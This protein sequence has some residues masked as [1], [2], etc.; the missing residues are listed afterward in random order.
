M[1]KKLNKI[2]LL[3]L[4]ALLATIGFVMTSCKED[5]TVS[6]S[7][8]EL[9]SFGPS[10]IQ[11]G[12]NIS[13]IGKNLDKVLSITF[14]GDSLTQSS[15]LKQ[16]PELIQA[17]VP[18]KA[19]R[20]T[21]ALRTLKGT[22]VSKTILDFLVPVTIGTFTSPVRPGNNITINGQ[23]VNYIKQVVFAKDLIVKD[24]FFVSRSVNHIVVKVPQ[25]AQT[26]TLNFVTGGTDPLTFTSATDLVVIL[27]AFTGY[28][29]NPVN[30]GDNLTITGT[31]LDLTQ[32]IY[33]N[34]VSAVVQTFV[35]KTATQI[36]VKVP[37]GS[38]KGRVTLV[39][40]SGVKVV[41]G[42]K[43][44]VT[45][46]LPAPAPLPYAFFMNGL[47]NGWG[48]WGWGGARNFKSTDFTRGDND[49]SIKVNCDASWG[50]VQFGGGSVATSTYTKV[51]FS[52]Y[53]GTGS[54]GKQ[55]QVMANWGT[56]TT[57]TLV[58]GVW[59]DYE[60]TMPALGNPGTITAL[61]FQEKGF[62][63]FYYLD[64]VGLR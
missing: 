19:E 29:P 34:G 53:G 35:S 3:P 51:V 20:G 26:G 16:T 54:S 61:I 47:Q 60:I 1:M 44:G 14:K 45:G 64:F 25:A 57:I 30:P 18:Q 11:H 21:V 55:I 38:V 13:F 41:S 63:G 17:L 33:F 46:D 27:P 7:E 58:P 31:N 32:G 10:G 28:T 59:T 43:L 42:T 12:D 6:S 15:F 40:Y 24:S 2:R 9:L 52:I 48:D 5:N 8:T 4:I 62:T 56:A 49:Y 39:A 23:F 22:I 36:V 50:A 37:V